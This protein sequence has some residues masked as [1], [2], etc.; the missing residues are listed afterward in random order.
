MLPQ[1]FVNS[2]S[3]RAVTYDGLKVNYGQ[4]EQLVCLFWQDIYNFRCPPIPYAADL[5]TNPTV[6]EFFEV[7]PVGQE[8]PWDVAIFGAS[9]SINSP[10]AGH[11]DIVLVPIEGGFIGWDSNWGNVTDQNVGTPGYGYPAAH[12]VQHSY[13]DIIGFLRYKELVMGVTIVGA[14]TSV[15]SPAGRIDIFAR[16]SDNN[17]YQ[18]YFTGVGWSNW[19][20]VGSG[21]YSSPTVPQPYSDDRID[22]FFTGSAGDLVHTYFNGQEWTP[23]ES[24][25][26]PE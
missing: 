9:A 26:E 24:L 10:V 16:G 7:I 15:G 3:G 18:K 25:G 19:V 22:V 12:Q 11:T 23:N 13:M 2:T 14:P 6:L 8:Q 1:Q 4:C 21:V 17:L 20:K 5:I